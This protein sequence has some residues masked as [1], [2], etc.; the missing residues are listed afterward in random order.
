[1]KKYNVLL[2]S[3]FI[4]FLIRTPLFSQSVVPDDFDQWIETGM[5]MWE[6]PGMAIAIVK[7]GEIAYT[8]GFGIKKIGSDERVD[9]HTQ[10]GI[11]SVSKHI[12]AMSLGLL[13]DQGLI[14]WK[15]PVRDYLPWFELSDPWATSNVTI[16]DL[17]THQVGVG[18][19][20]GNRLQ[21]MTDR[22]RYEMLHRMRYHDFEEP[23]RSEYVYSNVMYTLAGEIVTAVSGRDWDDFISIMMFDKL[24]MNRTN[25]SILDLD[26]S[27]AAWP[28]QYINGEVVPIPRRSWDNAAPAGGVNSTVADMAKW[29]VMQLNGG[30]VEGTRI[31]S[32]P[33]LNDIQTAKISLPNAN[34]NAPL[35]SYGYGYRITDFR[36]QR[37]LLHDGATDGMNTNYMI[38]PQHGFGVIVMTNTFNT[39]MNAVSYHLIDHMLGA[40]DQ[41]WKSLFHEAYTVQF[42]QTKSL[43]DEFDKTRLEGT[44]PSHSLNQFT[45]RYE[46]DLYDSVVISHED[47][48]LMLTLF[49]DDQLKAELEHWH[50]N[51][52]RIVWENR[53]L[54]E[55]FMQFHLDYEGNINELEIRFALR[56]MMLQVGAYPSDYYRDVTF[57]KSIY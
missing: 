5:E 40:S 15:D 24:G 36:G 56:P 25:S 2:L 39:F 21:F 16:H 10:F 6:I 30:E 7:N 20:L 47:G 3:L 41:D 54:R 57:I 32:Q 19:M 34:V 48:K 42:E 4:L 26:E 11:A 50:H 31:I 1:M 37:I 53:A 13:V 22:S 44:V 17:L 33:T 52:F 28:H 45:G 9:E 35:V 46:N 14:E 55:E 27:N 43:R 38:L 18:R 49:H 29:M 51:T 8:K 12:T 23:F